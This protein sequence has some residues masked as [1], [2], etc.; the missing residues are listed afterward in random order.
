MYIWTFVFCRLLAQEWI[1]T[2]NCLAIVS[3][4]RLQ[5]SQRHLRLC[6]KAA[7]AANFSSVTLLTNPGTQTYS[8]EEDLFFSSRTSRHTHIMWSE[9]RSGS[10]GIDNGGMSFRRS[11][12]TDGFDQNDSI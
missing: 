8:I 7:L 10:V 6:R 12:D 11:R 1:E 4:G 9:F 2:G 3:P 5:S